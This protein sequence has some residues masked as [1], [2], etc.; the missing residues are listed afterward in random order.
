MF[1]N[2]KTIISM[3]IIFIVFTIFLSYN[4]FFRNDNVEALSKYGS[5]GDEV[6][7]IQT[8]LKRW[9][10]YNG[11]IDGIYGSQT[12]AAVRWFQSKNGLVVDRNCREK[13]SSCNGN[14]EF[15]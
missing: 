13:Y 9:G 3:G 12:Q 15:F 11:N 7:Q 6:I 14:Y 8:K 4:I 5:R 10:Y 2:K 1:K